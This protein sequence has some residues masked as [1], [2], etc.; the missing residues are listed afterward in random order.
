MEHLLIADQDLFPLQVF[1][2]IGEEWDGGSF[3]GYP[4]R[5]QYDT[6]THKFT[7][8]DADNSPEASY[9]FYQTWLYFGLLSEVFLCEDAN[10]L[11]S[12]EEDNGSLVI[13][14]EYLAKVVQKWKDSLNAMPL[15]EKVKAISK[16]IQA[17]KRVHNELEEVN[18]PNPDH[19]IW[20]ENVPPQGVEAR[21]AIALLGDALGYSVASVCDQDLE[22][23]VDKYNSKWSRGGGEVVS[24]RYPYFRWGI[25]SALD[26]AMDEALL[27]PVEKEQLETASPTFVCYLLS[28]PD[29]NRYPG[30]HANCKDGTCVGNNIDDETYVTKHVD[31]D[32]ECEHDGP[33]IEDVKACLESGHIPTLSISIVDGEYQGM[34]VKGQKPEQASIWKRNQQK[35]GIAKS[36]DYVALSHVWS[37]G[38]G[39]PFKN[40]L[41]KCQLKRL[42]YYVNYTM[43]DGKSRGVLS[44][45]G[46]AFNLNKH[47][48]SKRSG[49]VWEQESNF[50]ISIWVD[51]MCVPLQKEYRKLAIKNM[52]QVYRQARYVMILDASVARHGFTSDEELMGRLVLST[53]MRRVWTLQEAVLGMEKL[54]IC[55]KDQ[56]INH[57]DAVERLRLAVTEGSRSVINGVLESVAMLGDDNFIGMNGAVAIMERNKGGFRLP[58]PAVSFEDQTLEMKQYI[59][60]LDNL[61]NV[62]GRRATTKEEDRVLVACNIVYKDVT[63]VLKGDGHT[64]R[65][66]A[67]LDQFEDVPSGVIFK[68]GERVPVDGYRWACH[69]FKGSSWGKFDLQNPGIV[70]QNGLIVKFPGF[71]LSQKPSKPSFPFI[72]KA[73]GKRNCYIASCTYPSATGTS[74]SPEDWKEI[75][76]RNPNELA[77][78][79]RHDGTFNHVMLLKDGGTVA[80]TQRRAILV[81]INK[82]QKGVIQCRYES[83]IWLSEAPSADYEKLLLADHPTIH[84]NS[85]L[86]SSQQW[87]VG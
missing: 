26:E 56:V 34:T 77:I 58:N 31:E 60:F 53:W 9:A 74:Q 86:P 63:K 27:C 66:T 25:L 14:T 44:S 72:A 49:T 36:L 5:R 17:I 2:L 87:C 6:V 45:F 71:I 55:T 24:P 61:W 37:D 79:I 15:P 39:N 7:Y 4:E 52:N 30:Q 33:V 83:F 62:I 69:N 8:E 46:K 57:T 50:D 85:L 42:A 23:A 84:S 43:N 59:I 68:S 21:F 18:V 51:T 12:R 40:T 1:P 81:S 65:M 19:F 29:T 20:T 22:N 75:I 64:G 32:C 82:E 54:A 38:L 78:I 10:E 48:F 70:T 3:D 67:L 76:N 80:C 41:P 11:F 47:Q 35:S 16:A 28:I 13:T 73:S